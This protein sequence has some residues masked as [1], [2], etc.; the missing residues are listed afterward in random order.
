M[1]IYKVQS[2]KKT[3]FNK[4]QLNYRMTK[5]EQKKSYLSQN[6]NINLKIV[7]E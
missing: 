6:K 4:H 5:Q 1:V 2:S 7:N 3:K